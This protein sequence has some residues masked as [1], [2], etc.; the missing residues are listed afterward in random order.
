MLNTKIFEKIS[1]EKIER[2]KLMKRHDK[3]YWF[4]VHEIQDVLN[5]VSDQYF[6]LSIDNNEVLP[7]S[8]TYFDTKDNKMYLD[9]HNGKLNRYKVR[10][11]T[12]VSSCTSF[13]EIKFKSN[14]GRTIKNRILIDSHK[15]NF[16]IPEETFLN[17]SLP[18]NTNELEP[19][20]QNRFNRVTLVNRNMKERCTID[21]NLQFENGSKTIYLDD[22]V[23]VE[24]KTEGITSNSPLIRALRDMRIKPSGF[25]KYCVGRTLTDDN[26]KNN[27]FKAKIR[28]IEK[29]LGLNQEIL[30]II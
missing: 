24:I 10:K 14:R 22:I 9:H 18:Y 6:A 5:Y 4:L 16:S 19:T 11:R 1:L 15:S 17:G 25:S 7:Y 8:T 27:S 21:L 3:K 12:Y 29:L 28:N 23:I 2:V 20:L 13:L 26:L 30:Q